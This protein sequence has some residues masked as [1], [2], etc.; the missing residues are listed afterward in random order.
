[1]D[2]INEGQA[3]AT[4]TAEVE[5]REAALSSELASLQ[6]LES[7][8]EER[9]EALNRKM[10]EAETRVAE[11]SAVAERMVASE[12]WRSTDRVSTSRLPGPAVGGGVGPRAVSTPPSPLTP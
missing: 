1:M 6:R 12:G 2:L 11:G 10:G 9:A 3:L 4:R 7:E 8:M 5:R